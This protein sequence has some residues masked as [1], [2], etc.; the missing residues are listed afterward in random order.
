MKKQV[1]HRALATGVSGGLCILGGLTTSAIATGCATTNAEENH[2]PQTTVKFT[3]ENNNQPVTII[4]EETFEVNL[5]SNAS[6]GYEWAIA[7]M[8]TQIIESLGKPTYVVPTNAPPGTP[9]RQ[10][11]RFKSKKVGHT[12]LLLNYVR[13]WEKDKKPVQTFM[14]DITVQEKK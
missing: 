5:E 7:K 8:D 6:T 1:S 2:K 11:F 10:V 3:E 13:P 14:L 4:R 9:S 12:K